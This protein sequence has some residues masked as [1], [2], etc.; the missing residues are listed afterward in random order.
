MQFEPLGKP[1]P[2]SCTKAVIALTLLAAPQTACALDN[3]LARTPMMG[4]NT[5]NTFKVGINETLVKQT[6]DLLVSLGLR[7]AGYQYMG[8]DGTP[9]PCACKAHCP[10]GRSRSS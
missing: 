4:Y 10:L 2:Y 3:V 7:D 5:C 1:A 9:K 8:L 6:S